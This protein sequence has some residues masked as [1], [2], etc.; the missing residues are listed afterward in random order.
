MKNLYKFFGFIAFAA[1]IGFTMTGCDPFAPDGFQQIVISGTLG[2]GGSQNVMSRTAY[3]PNAEKRFS[4]TVQSDNS[5]Q[6]ILED[7]AM[8]F[9]LTG[10]YNPETKAFS[11]QA[12]SS[13]MVFALTGK[14]TASN[15][16]DPLE[17]TAVLHVN[18]DG[19]WAT[20]SLGSITPSAAVVSGTANQTDE[21]I[22]PEWARGVWFDQLTGLRI[23]VSEKAI[24]MTDGMVIVPLNILEISNKTETA[25]IRSLE[26]LTRAVLFDPDM[27]AAP[28]NYTSRFYVAESWDAKLA[29]ALGNVK[30]N[31]IFDFLGEELGNTTLTEAQSMMTGNKMFIAPFC[32]QPGTGVMNFDDYNVD[33]YSPMFTADSDGTV[34]AKNATALK[35]IPTFFLALQPSMN[36]YFAPAV[37]TLTVTGLDEH[38]GKFITAESTSGNVSLMA[39]SEGFEGVQVQSG[40]VTLNVYS[41]VDTGNN[42]YQIVGYEGSGTFDLRINVSS[43]GSSETPPGDIEIGSAKNVIFASG[44]AT[45]EFI[46][47]P[48]ITITGLS[49]HNGKYA[50][51][52]ARAGDTIIS[53][54]HMNLTGSSGILIANGQVALKVSYGDQPYERVPV[55]DGDG[56]MTFDNNGNPIYIDVPK[57]NPDFF[58]GTG[59]VKF[60]VYISPVADNPFTNATEIGSALVDLA[61]FEGTGIYKA[62]PSIT[63]TGLNAHNG[64]YAV[65]EAFKEGEYNLT[66]FGNPVAHTRG[67]VQ[68]GQ[69]TLIIWEDNGG[70][71]FFTGNGEITFTVIIS[72][73]ADYMSTENDI[74]EGA[75]TVSFTNFES[76]SAVYVPPVKLTV[77]GLSA[78][79]GKYISGFAVGEKDPDT[80]ESP[81]IR[82]TAGTQ[83]G[84]KHGLITNGTAT[85][86]VYSGGRNI[87][88]GPLEFYF[89]IY[90]GS[91]P[92]ADE[93][94]QGDGTVTFTNRAGTCEFM[95]RQ[96]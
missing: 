24:S 72:T 95:P 82:A 65:A 51:A 20:I 76:A 86:N 94:I 11:M 38:N 85:L 35:P 31:E 45:A 61:N 46:P 3:D 40:Q 4:G 18:Q 39:R 69:V 84:N 83:I 42:T 52:D 9:R 19:N 78:Y 68:N 53:A 75:V 88:S 8:L 13:M 50:Y 23:A 77:T 70:N 55:L 10:V 16:I 21:N 22:T 48:R 7:G 15:A 80:D 41:I 2:G 36:N 32:A 73:T 92:N 57:A 66:A 34:A 59:E 56:N 33:G 49:A 64:K 87:G 12:A 6:G 93:I 28:I 44:I 5:I 1:I 17:S 30:L 29:G 60:D 14:L 47:A 25:G 58:D 63:I 89:S 37:G 96:Y 79:D 27:I 71:S 26:I 90:Q 81:H 62:P 91:V 67:L 74:E 43:S 54:G